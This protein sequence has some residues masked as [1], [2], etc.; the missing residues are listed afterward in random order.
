MVRPLTRTAASLAL[1]L[2]FGAGALAQSFTPDLNDPKVEARV[3]AALAKMT[4]DEKLGLIGGVDGFNIRA[5]PSLG[6]PKILM[7]DGPAGV[8]NYG[9]T[10]AYPAPLL[11]AAT[12]SP[13]LGRTYG[14]GLGRDARAR[15][16]H[17]LLAPGVN[18]Q[19]T[20]QN[21]RGFEYL[22]ED[23]FLTT[24]MAVGTI[25]GVQSQGVVATV[26]HYAGNE[27]ED[28][29][30][31]DDSVIAER[32]LREM[33][34]R[35]FEAAVKEAKVGAVMSS[36]N[37]FRG[38][39]AS[40]SEY[41]VNTI[42][43][44]EWGF[45]G[46]YM[47]DWGAAHSTVGTFKGG[48]D[49]EMPG[50]EFFNLAKLKPLL[51]SGEL[52]ETTLDDKVRRI[53]R[54]SLAFDFDKRPQTLDTIAKADPANE[55]TALA[56]ARAGVVLLQN[57][58]GTLPISL[59]ARR[60][61]V[62]G[63]NAEAP[64]T[65]GGGSSYTTPTTPVSLA[66]GLRR[67]A[68]KGTEI[69]VRRGIPSP[70][71]A[72]RRTD[73]R[74]PD[75]APGLKAEYWANRTL[76]G[77]PKLTRTDARVDFD[78]NGAPGAGLPAT[79]F[80]ARWTG[81]FTP[82]TTGD[83]TLAARTDD[84]VR[85]FV[86]DKIAIDAWTDRGAVTDL[87]SIR[88]EAG[89]TYRIRVDYYQGGGA[90]VARFGIA[91]PE[92]LRS[93]VTD[94]EIRAADTVI[95]AS[96][97]NSNLEGEGFDRKFAL[98][99]E[100]IALLTRVVNLNP[101]TTI[102]NNSGGPVDLAP[103]APKAGAMIQAFYPGGNGNLAVAEILFG[104]TNPSGRLPMSWPRTL[105]GTY[106]A[107]AY[108]AKKGR[109]VYDEGLYIGYRWFQRNGV[110]PLF[111]FGHG[112]SYT[113][114]RLSGFAVKPTASGAEASVTVRNVGRYAGAEVVQLYTGYRN[115]KIERPRRELKGF[116]RVELTPGESRT[117][118]I[119]ISRDSLAYWDVVKKAFRVEPGTVE[120]AVGS[121]SAYLPL[122]GAFT[123]R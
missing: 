19:R 109:M 58:G 43:K 117:V 65:G 26:K 92:D 28:D 108:P 21:G 40:E 52:K 8:R 3:E 41:L 102:V 15:G 62:V 82:K 18:L 1:L 105:A 7:S 20:V 12:F 35:P 83:F 46:I 80:S 121:S 98:P 112:L 42:L 75:G 69:T 90:A 30:N 5:V 63:P 81:T 17:I 118:T 45:R 94:A 47:S 97:L 86:D 64:A 122:R 78:W 89:R 9:P 87:K 23:P 50:P 85:V 16:V 116:A 99:D 79:D 27:H 29:R 110:A 100:Q 4:L 39:H 95:V 37:L 96:G 53:L 24:R 114:F 10:T 101:R 51:T 106:Y 34:L 2:A 38:V 115:G 60:V 88:L 93:D 120:V 123:V 49:L 54:T 84:G 76:E 36:Y 22:G 113:R 74:T 103:F 77:A 48:L 111:P 25:E 66:E 67:I 44:G 70:E 32:P 68:P 61:L 6:L 13:E 14:V 59:R 104:K 72:Y 31:H 11:L 33:Y 71:V 107:S 91:S 55:A 56:V 57:R 119:P 73:F